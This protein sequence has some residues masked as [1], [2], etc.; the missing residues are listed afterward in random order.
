MVVSA[1]GAS[2]QGL[3]LTNSLVVW[4]SRW[5][6]MVAEH[7]YVHAIPPGSGNPAQS[8]LGFFPLF[9]ILIRLV[10]FASPFSW[11]ITGLVTSFLVGAGASIAVWWM[12]R[13]VYGSLGADRGTALIF[14]APG[15][16]VFSLVYSEGAILLFAALSILALGRQRWIWAG[17][18]AAA[19]TATDPLGVVAVIPCVVACVGAIRTNRE[20]KAL[21]A[22]LLAPLGVVAFFGYLW[23]HTGSP[24]EYVRAQ[25]AGWQGGNLGA[26]VPRAFE[27]FFQHG[28]VDPNY[29]IKAICIFGAVG[30]LVLFVRAHP[31]ATWRAYVITALLFGVASPL[32]SIT[33]RLL[34]RAFPLLGA[35][36]ASLSKRWFFVALAL[37]TACL[38]TCT[39][40][41]TADN[42][43]P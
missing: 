42:W 4:D 1:I 24:F 33:P 30:L 31:P 25:R 34:E 15:A 14:F 5:Y 13:D 38:I 20:W 22:P 26:S 28:F 23:V 11:N 19:A 39:V 35:V 12:V 3:S 40:L 8:D 21:F 43:T 9:P 18:A 37:S 17:L 29:G 41:L 27:H 6:L 16:F 36:G 10:H 7:G 32:V 2:A